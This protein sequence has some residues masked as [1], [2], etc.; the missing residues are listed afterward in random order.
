MA[1][2]AQFRPK[3]VCTASASDR[4]PQRNARVKTL[5]AEGTEGAEDS[6]ERTNC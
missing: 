6:G 1:L 2:D 3:M 4:D 5:K